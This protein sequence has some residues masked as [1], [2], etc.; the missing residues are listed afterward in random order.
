M[1]DRRTYSERSAYLKLAVTK[2]RQQLR[3]KL[4][5]YK[6]G[7]C[8]I[9]GYKK[10]NGALECH[11]INNHSKLFGLSAKGLTRS[12]NAIK[13]EADKCLLVCSNCHKEIHAKITQPSKEILECKRGELRES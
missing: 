9:C 1:S 7:Q 8:Q 6:G 11:H 13:K 4:I 10:Y 3:E 5:L 12:W 2:R